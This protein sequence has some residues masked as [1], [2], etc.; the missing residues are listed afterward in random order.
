MCTHSLSTPAAP[1]TGSHRADRWD[2]TLV[3]LLKARYWAE[4]CETRCT[5]PFPAVCPSHSCWAFS[6]NLC[7]WD[8]LEA[9]SS[10]RDCES[11]GTLAQSSIAHSPVLVRWLIKQHG[12]TWTGQTLRLGI[13]DVKMCMTEKQ[14]KAWHESSCSCFLHSITCTDC[15]LY[16]HSDIKVNMTL[17]TLLI[18][19]PG[20]IA[21][22]SVLLLKTKTKSFC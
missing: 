5:K 17:L 14:I 1:G 7:S 18:H 12:S 6:L 4:S 10:S 21:H 8:S 2:V 20:L 13:S 19:I 22:T 16:I 11:T 3:R 9:N 15:F